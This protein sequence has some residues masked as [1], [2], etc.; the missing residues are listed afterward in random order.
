MLALSRE[1]PPLKGGVFVSADLPDK[2]IRSILQIR[3]K[4]GTSMLKRINLDPEKDWDFS[5]C[6]IAGDFIYTAHCGGKT[7]VADVAVQLE[8]AFLRLTQVL[9]AANASLDD[10]VQINM[11]L[12]DPADFPKTKA[13]FKQFFKNGFPAR[14]TYVSDFVAPGNLVQLDAIAYKPQAKIEG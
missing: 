9:A 8:A 4:T 13:V 2:N 11:L 12:K 1:T 5:S 7:A 10:V 3:M 6:V 14:T